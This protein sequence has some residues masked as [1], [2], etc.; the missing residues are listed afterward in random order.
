M[1]Q[2]STTE[3]A[4]LDNKKQSISDEI[5]EYMVWLVEIVSGRFF[6]NNKA[7][8]YKM[9]KEC[10]IWELYVQNYD[11]THTLSASYILQEI[12]E[13]LIVKGVL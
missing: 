10:G 9:L 8:T 1:R 6:N 7:L 4:V 12:Q 11:V 5:M 3:F 13:V 2:F